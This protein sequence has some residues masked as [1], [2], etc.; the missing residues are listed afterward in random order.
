MNTGNQGH[1]DENRR[2]VAAFDFDGTLTR[3]DTFLEF[4]RYVKGNGAYIFGLIVLFP[5]FLRHIFDQDRFKEIFL[6]HFFQGTRVEELTKKGKEFC[7][8]KMPGLIRSDIYERLE[9]HK[10]E[11]HL[12]LIVTASFSFWIAP[13]A[14]AMGIPCLCSE[15][16]VIAGK[17]SGKLKGSNCKGREKVRRLEEYLGHYKIT[18]VYAYGNSSGDN[19][20]LQWAN[21]GVWV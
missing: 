8:E 10:R 9:S 6:T 4:T 2:V 13:W 5:S 12:C 3:K 19:E 7:S 1:I 15:A 14:E 16:E 18:Y 20:M 11:G 17:L 21:E